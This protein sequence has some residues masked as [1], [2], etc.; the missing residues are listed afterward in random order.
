MTEPTDHAESI[1]ARRMGLNELLGLVLVRATTEEVVATLTIEAKH[2]QAYGLVHGGVHC[3]V[4]E[5]LCSIGAALNGLK[6]DQATVGLE[7]TTSF[8]R[9]VR[10]GETLTATAA[11]LRRGRRSQVWETVIED[12][13]GEVVA[14]G[15]VRLLN[16]D[17]GAA[18]AGAKVELPPE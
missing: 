2:T 1:N 8:L 12:S 9:A 11:P 4:V 5:T 3:A 18:L 16:L 14:S 7:N 13:T 15:R 10:A 6:N 17:P